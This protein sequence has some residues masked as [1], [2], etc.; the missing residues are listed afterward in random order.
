M[1][2][3]RWIAGITVNNP[4]S[5]KNLHNH[6]I[7]SP[8]AISAFVKESIISAV[9][10]SPRLTADDLAAGRGLQFIPGAVDNAATSKD[11]IRGIRRKHH[12]NTRMIRLKILTDFYTVSFQ[13]ALFS[14]TPR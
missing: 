1:F 11:K 8:T 9:T 4:P 10:A 13:T 12:K 5:S 2:A 7:H 6:K 3:Y 14:V